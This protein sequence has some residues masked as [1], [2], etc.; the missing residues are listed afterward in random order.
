VSKINPPWLPLSSRVGA[1][2]LFREQVK[3][4]IYSETLHP[5]V[6]VS[7]FANEKKGNLK[8]NLLQMVNFWKT[9][10]M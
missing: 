8:M 10:I 3:A 9:E 2:L 1:R 4:V 5:P 7:V 6:E